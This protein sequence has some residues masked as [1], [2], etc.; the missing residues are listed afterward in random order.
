MAI[1][2]GSLS[3][4]LGRKPALCLVILGSCCTSSIYLAIVF[5]QAPIEYLLIGDFVLGMSGGQALLLSTGA[6]YIADVTSEKSRMSRII[7]LETI[8]FVGKQSGNTSVT[9]RNP[10]PDQTDRPS[11]NCTITNGQVIGWF[12]FSLAMR[13][14]YIVNKI[15]RLPI[16]QFRI[17]P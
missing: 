15:M 2:I 7:I 13:L 3:D 17:T 4:R 12:G 10:T 5:F 16:S 8:F 11:T 9:P 14:G 6:S 1:L